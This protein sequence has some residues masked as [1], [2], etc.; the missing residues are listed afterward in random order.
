MNLLPRTPGGI[1][2]FT[3]RL[4]LG[5]LFVYSGWIKSRDT[6]GFLEDVRTFQILDDPYADLRLQG[7]LNFAFG[8][9]AQLALIGEIS[10]L[11]VKDTETYTAGA[12]F[13]FQF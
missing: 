9:N 8:A 11:L 2:A 4:L 1:V 6:I 3:L 13:A 7:G 10:G 5:G 12:N